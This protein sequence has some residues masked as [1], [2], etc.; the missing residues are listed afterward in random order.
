MSDPQMPTASTPASTSPARGP[1]SGS[2]R[3]TR[4]WSYAAFLSGGIEA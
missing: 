2:S 1:G 4:A 3:Y